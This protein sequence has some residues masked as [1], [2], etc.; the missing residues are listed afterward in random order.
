MEAGT[1]IPHG[2]PAA[3]NA[4]LLERVRELEDRL[5]RERSRSDGLARGLSAL[6]ERVVA[7]RKETGQSPAARASR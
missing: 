3:E 2:D 4:R 5:R 7:L 1:A 6:S